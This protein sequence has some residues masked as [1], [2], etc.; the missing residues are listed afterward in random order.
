MKIETLTQQIAAMYLGQK[1]DIKWLYT[2]TL[3]GAFKVGDVWF[4]SKIHGAHIVRLERE[5]V[6]ITL[7]LR[8]LDSLTEAEAR[9]LYEVYYGIEY[10]G[11]KWT[12]LEWFS[13]HIE[14]ASA[15]VLKDHIGSPAA[16]LHLLSL[17]F[18]LFGL[19]DAGLAK[20]ITNP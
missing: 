18:D 20:E 9:E 12:A 3:D 4:D 2:D 14:P 16:W 5:E 17:G 10:V 1:C 13:L 7:H 6:Q 11:T 15:T 8:R 19:I